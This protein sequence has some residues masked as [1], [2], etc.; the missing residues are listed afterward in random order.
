MIPPPF[1][2]KCREKED[3]L[4][5]LQKRIEGFNTQDR[6]AEINRIDLFTEFVSLVVKD[7]LRELIARLENHKAALQKCYDAMMTG[8]P[9]VR[10]DDTFYLLGN[11][12]YHALKACRECG[13]GTGQKEV[14]PDA[15]RPKDEE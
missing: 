4:H 6:V 14:K 10:G 11:T 8:Q 3:D 7:N 1:T 12:V 15:E 5:V 2:M 13:I 9:E